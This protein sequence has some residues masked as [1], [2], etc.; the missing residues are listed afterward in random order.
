MRRIVSGIL[1]MGLFGLLFACSTSIPVTVTKPAEIN[2]SGNRVIAVL[3]FRYPVKGTT[4]SGRDLLQ[5]AISKLTGLNL[6]SQLNVEQRVADYTTDQVI[7]ALLNT[8]YFQLVSPQEVAQRMRGGISSTTTAV[9]IGRA[10]KAQAIIN[11]ELYLLEARDQQWIEERTI[12]DSE[13]GEEKTV[14]VSMV[15]RTARV[16]M[17]YQV[18]NTASGNVVASRSFED[19]ST[20]DQEWEYRH[21]LPD[22]EDMYTDIIDTFMPRMAKQLA[23]YQVRENRTLMRDKTKNP[24]ME[25][26][27]E[28][29]KGKIYDSA[30]EIFLSVW[31]GDGNVA[32]GFNAAIIYEVIGNLDMAISQMK[33]VV[34]RTAD[35]KAIREYHR[36][37]GAKQDQERLRQQQG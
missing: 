6:P 31:R 7:L 1:I 9:D 4:I 18:V 8:G 22:A 14:N 3:D 20:A 19:Q 12:T 37:L 32:A 30:L 27:D 36:L 10:V 34:E 24:R 23:P 13:T 29:V 28:L 35:K 26:A 16:G 25:Q 2:M 5:W 17:T 11:G 21:N 15:K 33:S